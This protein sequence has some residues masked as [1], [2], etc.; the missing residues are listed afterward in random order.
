MTAQALAEARGPRTRA[1]IA[2]DQ[3]GCPAR[4]RAIASALPDLPLIAD[5]AC[6]LGSHDGARAC[7]SSGVIAC[8]SFHP[9]KVVTTG[10]GG[11]CLTDDPDL[12]AR[13]RELRNHGQ[14]APGTFQRAS[15]NHRLTEVAAAIGIVQLGRLDAMLS[16]RRALAERYTRA[17]SAY[18][19]Q[20]IPD[21]AR[22][23][24]QT[25][26]VV[27]PAHARRDAVIAALRERGIESGRLSY[28]LHTLPQFAAAAASARAAER[29]FP[30]SSMLAER[31]LALPLWPGLSDSDQV[32]VIEGLDSVLGP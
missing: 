1:A 21:G 13:L 15:G 31:G 14:S 20:R 30:V 4:M 17:L 28:A 2:I 18:T 16:E 6:S 7:G 10:E 8:L 19:P 26:G 27:L 32:K 24:H 23:N 22:C 9:R 11:M 5:A 3:F 12:A 25:Y 29:S